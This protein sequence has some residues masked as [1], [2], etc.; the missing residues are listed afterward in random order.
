[1]SI[2]QTN[3]PRLETLVLTVF[4]DF[5]L[6]VL[7]YDSSQTD[8]DSVNEA[9][10]KSWVD[11]LFHAAQASVVTASECSRGSLTMQTIA[12]LRSLRSR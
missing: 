8:L 6:T 3:L 2:Q 10:A 4:C 5:S 12:M 11:D 7:V 9:V 1:M